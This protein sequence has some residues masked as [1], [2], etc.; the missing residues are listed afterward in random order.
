MARGSRFTAVLNFFRE[1][2]AD[3]VRAI[4]PLIIETCGQ[5]KILINT[6]AAAPVRTGP[7]RHR[8]TKA[9]MA[10]AST[11][12]NGETPVTSTAAA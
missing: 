8:R 10:A 3:E 5:R 2:N 11:R 9:E 12:L 6:M 4:M 1:G 7:K